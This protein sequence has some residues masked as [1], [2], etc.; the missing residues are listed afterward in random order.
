MFGLF[1]NNDEEK[2]AA[3]LKAAELKAEAERKLEEAKLEAARIAAEQAEKA[4]KEAEAKAEEMKRA[5]EDAKAKDGECGVWIMNTF[6]FCMK[7]NEL[8]K[9]PAIDDVPP[10]GVAAA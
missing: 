6:S 7:G 10:T 1:G 5:L 9:A 4:K 3:E 2:K 8:K